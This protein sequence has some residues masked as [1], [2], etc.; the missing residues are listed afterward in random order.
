MKAVVFHKP[1]DMRVENVEDPKIVDQT[2]AIIKVTATAICGSDLHIYN[3]YFPQLKNMVMG[4]EFMGVVEAVGSQVTKVKKGDRVTVPFVISCGS[5]WF[6]SHK[7]PTSCETTNPKH[8]G[9]EGGI[10]SQKGGG[11]FGF[12]DLYGGY[13]G[14]QAE[15][16][17]VPFADVGPRVIPDD[18]SDEQVLFLTDILPTAY[19][20]LK[21]ADVKAGESV[22]IFGSGPV[23]LMAQ[24]LAAMMGASQVIAVDPQQYRLNMAKEAGHAS[25]VVNPDREDPVDAIRSL[26]KGRGADVCID[27]VGMEA[28]RSLLE[29]VSNVVHLQGGTMKVVETAMSAVRRNG[30]ISVVGVYGTKYDGFNLA[31]LF[32]KNIT[33]KAGQAWVQNY[34]DELLSFI[35]SGKIRANDIITHRYALK[36][37]PH[38]YEI[39]NKKEDGCVKVV[40]KPW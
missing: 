3:G 26:T 15:Y 37:A 29:K 13:S 7:F 8:Y 32:D 25:H 30:R 5:C 12:T 38:A 16:A 6:C 20:A 27:A 36:D 24:K 33:I 10:L 22:A 4:H 21:W 9:P 23:G 1:G 39:F 28:K 14:G 17:R 34:E 2:D 11:L 35:K 40:L 19:S 31:Q 18:L